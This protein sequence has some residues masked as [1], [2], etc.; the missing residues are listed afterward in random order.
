VSATDVLVSFVR[1]LDPSSLRE[2]TLHR[3]CWIML[4]LVGVAVAG[5][6]T[7][8][9]RAA[10]RFAYDQYQ[11]GPATVI[12][13]GSPLCVLGATWTNGIAAS[14]LDL[15]EG[16]RL[17]MGHPA[18]AVVPACLAVAE[19]VG[20][21]GPELLAAVVAGYEVA[22]RSSIARVPT[23]KDRQY[24]SG[25]WG[26]LGS[27]AAAGKLLG[28]D[29]EG[30]QSALG[31]AASHGPFP[32]AG[33]AANYSMAKEVIGWAGM[34]GCAAALL[35]QQG[36]MGPRDVMDYSGRWDTELLVRDLGDPDSYA[37]LGGYF[38]LYAVCRWAHAPIDAILTLVQREDL[39]P[40]EIH[41]VVVETFYEGTRL[42]DYA[43]ET[44]I[45]AQFSIPFAV[46]LAIRYHEVGLSEVSEANLRDPDLL[47]LARQ[48]EVVVDPELDRLY[49]EETAARVTLHTR[50]GSFRATVHYPLGSPENPLSEDQLEGKFRSLTA[51]A[52]GEATSRQLQEA[53]LALPRA[54]SVTTLTR[55]LRFRSV[56]EEGRRVRY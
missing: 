42:L 52:L 24:S 30:L 23:Y 44:V 27:A 4:D 35:A 10:T 36:F 17:A 31:N 8:M 2:P 43:P 9:A 41:R 45:A 21:T 13:S 5:A 20:A 7:E 37:V 40:D 16:H 48:V 47:S 26:V 34:T 55:L 53:I 14:A 32:P 6:H 25:I 11:P 46:A 50:R 15:D 56:D 49:P 18:A 1:Q 38:K 22:V 28:L 12:G 51:D 39:R 54:E 19:S 33:P 29:E 3:T